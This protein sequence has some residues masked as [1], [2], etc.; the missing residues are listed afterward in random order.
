[1][2]TTY[3]K[4]LAS[5]FGGNI[6]LATLHTE[7]VNDG[8]IVPNLN[9]INMTDDVIDIIFDS[10]LSAGEQTTLDNIISSHDSSATYST[11]QVVDINPRNGFYSTSDYI[12]VASLVYQGDIY[13]N[14]NKIFVASYMDPAITSYDIKVEDITNNNVIVIKN[15]TN[16]AEVINNLGTLSNIPTNQAKLEV[17]IKKTGGPAGKKVYVDTISFHLA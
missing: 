14:I 3:T 15:L 17:Q 9:G 10:S 7:I 4:S 16:T 1:M 5:D 6:N 11:I 12:R 2:A 13:N 8:G